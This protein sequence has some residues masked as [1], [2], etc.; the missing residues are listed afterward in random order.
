MRDKLAG[1][2]L[3]MGEHF[4]E[5]L[6]VVFEF[7]GVADPSLLMPRNVSPIPCSTAASEPG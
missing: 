1:R 6:R 3:L 2:L 7:F 5:L 4:R